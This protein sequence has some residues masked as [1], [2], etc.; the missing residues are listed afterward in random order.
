MNQGFSHK[1]D[2]ISGVQDVRI[3]Q[4]GGLGLITLHRPEAL[5]A[6]NLEMIRQIAGALDRWQRDPSVQAVFFR[7]SGERAFCAGG[8]LKLFHQAGMSLRKGE[9][10]SRVPAV[11]FAEEYSLNRQI[12][13]YPKPT[14]AFMNGITMGGGFGLAG[15]CAHRIV[16]E[17]TVFAMPE[18]GIGFF[19]DVGSVYHLLRCPAGVGNYLALTGERLT[20]AEV[21]QAGLGDYYVPRENESNIIEQLQ[22]PSLNDREIRAVIDSFA[23]GSLPDTD[24]SRHM[25]LIARIFE[26]PDVMNIFK[27]LAQDGSPWASAVFDLM[28]TRSPASVMVTAEHLAGAQGQEFDDVIRTDFILAQRFIERMDLYEGI[29]AVLI[30]KGSKPQWDPARFEDIAPA[31]VAQYFKP[32]GYDLDDVQ[33]FASDVI[34]LT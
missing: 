25:P 26:A 14:V 2:K 17:K 27:L 3:E 13:H 34:L 21:M 31:D 29:R 23:L 19:P 16:T 24:F 4:R 11:F 32:T 1:Q 18:V 12:F 15:N 28:K 8:D 5:N 30:E 6:L 9:V 7:G 22:K 33:I 20:G 10:D